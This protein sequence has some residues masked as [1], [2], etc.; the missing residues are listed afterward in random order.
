MRSVKWIE[1]GPRMTRIEGYCA[2]KNA[3]NVDCVETACGMFVHFSLG[4]ERRKA[5]CPQCLARLVGTGDVGV[6]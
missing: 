3:T 6:P 1:R 5:T 4:V 2:V